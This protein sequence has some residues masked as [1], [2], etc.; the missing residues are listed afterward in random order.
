MTQLTITNILSLII[1]LLHSTLAHYYRIPI[2]VIVGDDDDPYL[3]AIKYAVSMHETNDSSPYTLNLVVEKADKEDIYQV[4][5]AVCKILNRGVFTIMAPTTFAT[6]NTL[7][8]YSNNFHIPLISPSFPEIPP[9]HSTKFGIGIL[10]SPIRATLDLMRHN[11]WNSIIYLYDAEDGAENFQK[12]LLYASDVYQVNVIGMHRVIS[13]EDAISYIR[14]IDIAN[15]QLPKQVLLKMNQKLVVKIITLFMHDYHIN[16]KKF[17]FL[18]MDPVLNNFW[19]TNSATFG[20]VNLLGFRLVNPVNEKY[21]HFKNMWKHLN[22]HKINSSL[23]VMQDVPMNAILGYDG[24]LLLL[25]TIE[26]LFSFQSHNPRFHLPSILNGTRKYCFQSQKPRWEHGALIYKYLKETVVPMGLTG[27]LKFDASGERYSFNL[28]IIETLP[29]GYEMSEPFLMKK[30]GPCS[31]N[32]CFEGFCKDLAD[33]LIQKLG[34]SY[35]LQLV[36]DGTYGYVDPVTQLWTGMIGEVISGK[37]TLAIAPLT[38]NSKRSQVVQFSKPFQTIGISL[39]V[40]KPGSRDSNPVG[41]TPF[42]FLYVFTKEVWIC[43]I[44]TYAVITTLLF[45]VT[46]FTGPPDRSKDYEISQKNKLTVC[47]TMWFTMGS[48]LLRGTGIYPKSISARVLSCIWWAFTLT[49][50]SLY[51][52]NAATILV[53]HRLGAENSANT[54]ALTTRGIQSVLEDAINSGIPELGC[55]KG[56]S[57]EESISARVLSCIWWAFTLTIISLYIANAATILVA[58]RLGAENS[59]NTAALTTRGIQSVLE[60]AINSGI[61]ELGCVKGGSTEDFFKNSQMTLYKKVYDS[62]Q[63]KPENL[64]S[65]TADGV[66]KLRESNGKYAIFVESTFNEYTSHREPCDTMM[67]PGTLDTKSYA[68]ASMFNSS[69]SNDRINEALHKLHETGYLNELYDKWWLRTS[70]CARRYSRSLEVVFL[71]YNILSHSNLCLL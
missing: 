34:L 9:E 3:T 41:T 12:L 28:D 65:S 38:V 56:G 68:V 43:V 39:M 6:Y 27:N 1:I 4:D 35:R 70:E 22:S 29:S 30:S 26:N 5:K 61:P 7:A 42:F 31:G 16:K 53:A 2:G 51:I 66:K 40:K 19:E 71:N 50:I 37:A 32:D 60:D 13:A 18:Y 67:V 48:F 52:A 21:M 24:V 64:F 55:V 33:A 20:S 36:A 58:H 14:K 46:K 8:S 57:T 25:K 15:K 17:S 45:F 59:A 23:S 63:R 11:N 44:V 10:P 47:S 54:A 49:I 69:I 62:F